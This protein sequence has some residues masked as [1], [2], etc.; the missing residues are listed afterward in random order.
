VTDDDD[1]DDDGGGGGNVTQRDAEQPH[2][3][4]VIWWCVFVHVVRKEEICKAYIMFVL[5]L[6]LLLLLLFDCIFL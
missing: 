1:D 4:T 6:L 2:M 3:P 5:I